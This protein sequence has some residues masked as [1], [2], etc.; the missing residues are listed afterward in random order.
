[1]QASDLS[2]GAARRGPSNPHDLGPPRLRYGAL[3]PPRV[4]AV[5]AP[6]LHGAALLTHPFADARFC[7]RR[8]RESDRGRLN[9]L[10]ERCV[11]RSDRSELARNGNALHAPENRDCLFSA[12]ARRRSQPGGGQRFWVLIPCQPALRLGGFGVRAGELLVDNRGICWSRNAVQIN[13]LCI[14]NQLNVGCRNTSAVSHRE[15]GLVD[16]MES[17]SVPRVPTGCSA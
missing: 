14:N 10:A 15:P 4:F 5:E 11:G 9:L 1:M 12:L 2:D 3:G 6:V 16:G 7:R 13:D 8:M 17:T